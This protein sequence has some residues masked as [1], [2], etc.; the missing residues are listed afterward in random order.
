MKK[1]HIRGTHIEACPLVLGTDYYGKTIPEDTAYSLIETFCQKGGNIIDTAHVYSDYLPGEKHM[2]EK[3]IGRWL[4]QSG[5]DKEL[6]K[7][8]YIATKG[9]F[10]EVGDMH[11]SRLSYKEV[12]QDLEESLECLQ[13]NSIDLYW[14]HRDNTAIPADEIVGWMDEFVKTGKIKSYGVSNWTAERIKKARKAA[15]L[16]KNTAPVASQIRWSMAVTEKATRED[17]TLVEMDPPEYEYYKN[18]DMAVFAFSS[19]AKGFFAKLKKEGGAYIKPEGKAGARYFNEQN[20]KTYE[21]LQKLSQK[22]GISEMQLALAW[23]TYAPFPAF[24]IIGCKSTAQLEDS[25]KTLEYCS[26]GDNV[27]EEFKAQYKESD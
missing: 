23:L 9:G 27:I 8:L 20:I 16:Q 5:K 14:L 19:Q 11:A 1:Q 17:D 15:E 7:S 2:S 4:R 12:K 13:I 26:E 25:M 21:K 24:P 6:G 10:P 18:N 3:V 22:Y